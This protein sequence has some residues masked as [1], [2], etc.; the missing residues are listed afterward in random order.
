MFDV[1]A[2]FISSEFPDDNISINR[3][4]SPPEIEILPKRL[5]FPIVK[6]FRRPVSIFYYIFS[7]I[8]SFHFR[9][10]LTFYESTREDT[11]GNNLS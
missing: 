4:S 11:N 5:T 9:I 2:N 3:S 1:S 6:S 8:E 10:C 7:L